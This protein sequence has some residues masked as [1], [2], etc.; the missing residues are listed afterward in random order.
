MAR[1]KRF[2]EC[3]YCSSVFK[4]K[5]STSRYCSR[6]CQTTH[7]RRIGVIPNRKRIGLSLKCPVCEK[8]F[9]IPQYRINKSDAHYCSRSCLAKVHFAKFDGGFKKLGRP[10]RKYKYVHINGKRM[11]EHRHL[12]QEHLGRKLMPLEHVHHINGDWLDNRLEN[13]VLLSNADHQRV[14]LF[15]AG[16]SKEPPTFSFETPISLRARLLPRPARDS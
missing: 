12:M 2:A 4:M 11:R 13:L 7:L 10:Q 14:E 1:P 8:T 3:A 6:S 5:G 16:H 15:E 9:Y